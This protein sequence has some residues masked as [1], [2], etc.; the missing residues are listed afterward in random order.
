[1]SSKCPTCGYEVFSSDF[2]VVAYPDVSLV[3]CKA[4]LA[5]LL[6]STYGDENFL[7]PSPFVLNPKI[8]FC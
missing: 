7:I 3:V 5:S 2:R 6:G 8:S 4:C 1:M